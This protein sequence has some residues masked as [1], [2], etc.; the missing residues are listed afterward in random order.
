VS[1]SDGRWGPLTSRFRARLSLV[2]GNVRY[3]YY[4]VQLHQPCTSYVICKPSQS[5]H[6]SILLQ[7]PCMFRSVLRSLLS[8]IP[9]LLS[10]MPI[11]LLMACGDVVIVFSLDKVHTDRSVRRASASEERCN[12]NHM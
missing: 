3:R 1:S 5:H 7:R 4:E 2:R 10:P 8:E 12:T 9:S 11:L 6:R